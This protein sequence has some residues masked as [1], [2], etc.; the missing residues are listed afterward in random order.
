MRNTLVVVM[1]STAALC[2]CGEKAG[3]GD[4][5]GLVNWEKAP[6]LTAG[7]DEGA[8]QGPMT[9]GA[10]PAGGPGGPGAA[11]GEQGQARPAS[12]PAAAAPGTVPVRKAGLWQTTMNTG[13]GAQSGQLCVDENTEL[14]RG[15]FSQ[16]GGGGRGPGC[17]PKIAKSGANW[18][19]SMSCTRSFGDA[20]VKMSSSQTLSGDL[21][22]SYQLKGSS[23]TSGGPNPEM[24]GTRQ[25]SGSGTYVGACPSGM[26]AGDF[27]GADGQVRNIMQQGQGR[28]PGGG[29]GGRR[30]GGGGA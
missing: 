30:E 13:R 18:T 28:G 21:S 10:T 22:K 7:V 24:N 2:S 6:P 16:G 15:V 23:T 5:T 9:P 25:I 27:K 4:Q 29:G 11:P 26:K 19:Y 17:D 14:R 8:N 20:E 12:A 1:L 3:G